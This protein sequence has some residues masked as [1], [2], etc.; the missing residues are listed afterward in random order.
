ME[1][2]CTLKTTKLSGHGTR[3]ISWPSSLP[4]AAR[5]SSGGPAGLSAALRDMVNAP[6][7]SAYADP[8][9]NELSSRT[10]IEK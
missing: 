1:I 9:F 2:E 3:Y 7:R 6:I 5:M 8:A 4:E 10:A